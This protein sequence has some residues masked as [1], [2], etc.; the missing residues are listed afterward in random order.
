MSLTKLAFSVWTFLNLDSALSLNFSR[1]E[2]YSWTKVLL[3]WLKAVS[4]PWQNIL[5]DRVLY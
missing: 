2:Q 5:I 4:L 3:A 1:P